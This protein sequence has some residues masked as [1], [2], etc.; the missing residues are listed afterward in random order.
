MSTECFFS[1][2]HL[3][4]NLARFRKIHL[5]YFLFV[6]LALDVLVFRI[7]D[8]E[9]ALNQILDLE[10]FFFLSGNFRNSFLYFVAVKI[11]YNRTI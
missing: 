5:K 9:S 4:T 7:V 2:S 3:N 10:K 6:S 11:F 8:E 1:S